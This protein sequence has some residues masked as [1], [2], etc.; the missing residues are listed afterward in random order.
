MEAVLKLAVG[1]VL[2]LLGTG[3]L[4]H[5]KG[6]MRFHALA[7]ELVLNDQ[8]LLLHRRRWGILFLAAAVVFLYSGFVNLHV[9][10][11]LRPLPPSRALSR[12]A[13]DSFQK[14]LYP[15]ATRRAAAL[16][17]RHPQDWNAR[18]LLGASLAAQGRMRQAQTVWRST[19]AVTGLLP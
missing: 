7:R 16:L 9:E 17:N 13:H 2:L 6:V 3:Y 1:I 12:E 19:G 4:Y 14:G 5:P 15:Q 18:L 8:Y 11:N 10:S